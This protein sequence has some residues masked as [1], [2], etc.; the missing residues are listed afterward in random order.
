MLKPDA[1]GS[2]QFVS[3]KKQLGIDS[4]GRVAEIIIQDTIKYL[5]T[6]KAIFV[7]TTEGVELI[8]PETEIEKIFF[9]RQ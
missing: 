3:E 1:S 5:K 9:I 6:D 7:I 2:L 8:K 4:I